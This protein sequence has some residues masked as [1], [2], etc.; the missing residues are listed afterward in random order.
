MYA[1]GLMSKF[2]NQFPELKESD[3]MLYLYSIAGFSAR[4]ISILI[5]EKIEVVYNRKS[6]LKTKIKNSKSENKTLFLN[7]LG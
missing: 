5:D 2:R 4:A 7:Y 3:C 1:D 6:R